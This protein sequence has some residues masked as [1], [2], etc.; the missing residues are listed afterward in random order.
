[1]LLILL[2][3]HHVFLSRNLMDVCFQ[4]NLEESWTEQSGIQS[5]DMASLL[6]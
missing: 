4:R 3:I 2:K 6:A 1:M 5:H